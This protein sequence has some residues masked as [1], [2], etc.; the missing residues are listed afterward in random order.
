MMCFKFF[1]IFGVVLIATL[2]GII[3]NTREGE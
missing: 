2:I 1:I 3:K